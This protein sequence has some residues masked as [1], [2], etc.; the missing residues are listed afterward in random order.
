MTWLCRPL[1]RATRQQLTSPTILTTFR[2][3]RLAPAPYINDPQLCLAYAYHR[4]I[5]ELRQKLEDLERKMEEASTL[6]RR[7]K[8]ELQGTLF[9]HGIEQV[10]QRCG[11]NTRQ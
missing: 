8:V 1:A 11:V 2:S 4:Q 6:A 7:R 5:L 10:R 3:F 9:H